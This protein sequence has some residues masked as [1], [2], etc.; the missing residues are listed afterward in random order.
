MAVSLNIRGSSWIILEIAAYEDVSL[1]TEVKL[2][3]ARCYYYEVT[4]V[5]TAEEAIQSCFPPQVFSK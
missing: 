2:G 1:S 5:K 3:V 4:E